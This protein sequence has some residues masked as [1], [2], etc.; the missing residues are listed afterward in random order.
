MVGHDPHD[1]G[2]KYLDDGGIDS[3]GHDS[4]RSLFSPPELDSDSTD[5]ELSFKTE[6]NG[7]HKLLPEDAAPVAER[8][9]TGDSAG[10]N[11]ISFTFCWFH[12]G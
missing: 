10:G 12:R 1:G 4:L 2:N 8:S 5:T 7:L 9:R 11:L 6:P 3:N